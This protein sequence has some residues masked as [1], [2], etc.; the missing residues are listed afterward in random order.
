MGLLPSTW[1]GIDSLGEDVTC[2]LVG[3]VIDGPNCEVCD[4]CELES[5]HPGGVNILW[6]G[7]GV[8]FVAEGI[9]SQTYQ[10]MSRR[11][12][13]HLWIATTQTP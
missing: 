12:A 10:T 4:E 11:L 8:Q 6:G 3:A 9:D 5:R 13:T 2:R 7:G 1:L